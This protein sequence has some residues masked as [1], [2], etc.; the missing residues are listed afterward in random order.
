L[1]A[2]LTIWRWGRQNKLPRGKPIGSFEKWAEWCR[3]PLLALGARDPVDRIAEIKA[4]DPERLKTVAIFD[5]WWQAHA[6]ALLKAVDLDPTVIMQIDDKAAFRDGSLQ[7]NRQFVAGQVAGLIDTHIGGYAL[8]K[9]Q[10]GPRSKRTSHYKL[11]Q[12]PDEGN[13]A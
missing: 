2:A 13:A 8:K 7:C 11:T 6:D 12:T 9:I 1:A 10:I 3:D 4:A 5:A